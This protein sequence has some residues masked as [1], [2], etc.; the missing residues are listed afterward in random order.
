M[1]GGSHLRTARIERDCWNDRQPLVP[2]IVA[3]TPTPS[4]RATFEPEVVQSVAVSDATDLSGA[5]PL[6]VSGGSKLTEPLSPPQVTLPVATRLELP[7]LPP[8]QL[9]RGN[10]ISETAPTT[11]TIRNFM[12][13]PCDYP[14]ERFSVEEVESNRHLS[15]ALGHG[16]ASR[17]GTSCRCC[18]IVSGYSQTDS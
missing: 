12:L 2:V 16:P 13:A 7:P 10:A 8:P 18:L 15:T 9:E 6:N 11:V 14:N 17:P 5:V 1:V 4:T 3:V